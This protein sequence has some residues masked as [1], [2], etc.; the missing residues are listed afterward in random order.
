MSK[1]KVLRVRPN[2]FLYELFDNRMN[3]TGHIKHAMDISGL[4]WETV[5]NIMANLT[6]QGY[7]QAEIIEVK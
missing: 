5:A 4:D 1:R 3:T 6:Q 7:H 2:E